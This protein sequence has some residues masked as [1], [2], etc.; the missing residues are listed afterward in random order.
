M[1]R[2]G[3]DVVIGV[4]EVTG[5]WGKIIDAQ[6]RDEEGRQFLGRLRPVFREDTPV[7][8]MMGVCIP[9][10]VVVDEML[11]L[12]DLLSGQRGPIWDAVRRAKGVVDPDVTPAIA[13]PDHGLAEDATPAQ[14]KTFYEDINARR[15]VIE[16]AC[17]ALL[18]RPASKMPGFTPV[19]RT[20]ESG[21]AHRA[22]VASWEKDIK[23]VYMRAW[24]ASGGLVE[25]IVS[26]DVGEPNHPVMD[27]PG[28]V[29]DELQKSFGTPDDI[30]WREE[31]SRR[32]P[33]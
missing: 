13:V 7:A 24:R 32:P 15:Q 16:D 23:D 31:Q 26:L 10:G 20:D 5:P 11:S 8:V 9:P 19:T 18:D 14:R 33:C 22:L 6:K 1:M 21:V 28:R 4:P 30:L 12:D 29:P 27:L 25:E 3:H 2:S 17:R